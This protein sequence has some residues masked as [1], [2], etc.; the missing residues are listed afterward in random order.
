VNALHRSRAP[1]E[2]LQAGCERWLLAHRGFFTP[3]PERGEVR[4]PLKAL[5]EL[6]LVLTPRAGKAAH[7]AFVAEQIAFAAGALAGL[8]LDT[9]RIRD[10]RFVLPLLVT[11]A[12]LEAAGRD[13]S[14]VRA[15][16]ERALAVRPAGTVGFATPYRRLELLMLLE[17]TGFAARDDAR[18]AR[19]YAGCRAPLDRGLRAFGHDEL[20]GLTHLVFAVSHHGAADPR[21]RLG[22][23]ETARLRWLVR[24]CAGI[25]LIEENLDL[26]GE[27]VLC[28]QL[29][30]DGDG[31]LAERALAL[32]AAAQTTGGAVPQ[33]PGERVEPDAS[34]HPTLMWSYAAAA[35]ALAR[36]R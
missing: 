14:A 20:Y 29:L 4:A 16:A 22:E 13:A 12:F 11:V 27:L 26:L 18:F 2:H 25:A 24:T 31:R 15:V 28:A 9:M 21:E 34:Y 17:R 36:P 35:H 33:R 5:V 8:D 1:G 10:P 32:A 19:A 30:R 3:R 6:M 7:D 23:L